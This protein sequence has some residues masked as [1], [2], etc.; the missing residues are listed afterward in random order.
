MAAKDGKTEQWEQEARSLLGPLT[1]QE[2]RARPALA[3]AAM[4]R[5]YASLS[6]RD[7]VEFSTTVLVKEHLW[8]SIGALAALL[9]P[10]SGRTENRD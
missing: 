9:R 8:S 6:V 4:N 10:A 1:E 7:I 2:P 3:E 5:A